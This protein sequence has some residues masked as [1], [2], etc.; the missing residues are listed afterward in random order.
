MKK[1]KKLLSIMTVLLLIVCMAVPVSAES[2]YNTG[3]TESGDFVVGIGELQEFSQ[4]VVSGNLYITQG[5]IYTFYGTLTVTGNVIVLGDFYNY[6]T[7]N[8]NGYVYCLNYYKDRTLVNTATKTINGI[9]QG[10]SYGNLWNN[11]QIN[12]NI[13]VNAGTDNIIPPTIHI[14]TPGAEATCTADQVCTSCGKV[15]KPATGHTPGMDAGCTTPQTCIKCGKILKAAKGHMLGPEATCT[16]NQTCMRCGEVIKKATGHIGGKTAT[17]TEPQY[18][19]QCGKVLA[20][21]TGHNW[22]DWKVE[23]AAT[24]CSPAEITRRCFKCGKKD[25]KYGDAIFPTG[26]TNYKNVILQKGKSTTDVRIIGIVNG[27]YLKTVI[28]KNRKLAKITAVKQDGSFKITALK[29]TGKTIITAT[30]ASGFTVN[31]NLTVKNKAVKTV[32]LSVNKSTVNLSIGKTFAIKATKTPFT[33]KDSIKYFSSNKK[34]ATVSSKGKI[35]AKKNGT[36]YIT[37]KSGNISKKIR[38][39]V[40]KFSSPFSA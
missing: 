40:K 30:L 20:E 38:I 29:K 15:I 11:G 28:P 26:K 16:S 14:H 12:G 32:K 4:R 35:T 19:T 8:V 25:T 5:S 33:S 7:I 23:K 31:I 2:S 24:Y 10:F 36:A 1:S 22:S 13:S 27:D 3:Y 18:C 34:I 37:V 21:P 9:K 6:G 39:V 17:C